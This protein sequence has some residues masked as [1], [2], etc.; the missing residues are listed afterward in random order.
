MS[1]GA[2]PNPSTSARTGII[3]VGGQWFTV[4]QEPNLAA[5]MYS[6]ERTR[7]SHRRRRWIRQREGVRGLAVSVDRGVE[8]SGVADDQRR[9]DRER[10]RYGELCRGGAAVARR[11]HRNADGCR[12]DLYG[13]ADDGGITDQTGQRGFDGLATD[14]NSSRF[15]PAISADG[16]WIAFDSK[17]SNL[18]AG[19]TNGL[20]DIFVYDAQTAT[21]ARVSVGP[22]GAQA[23]DNSGH[24]AI[25]ADGRFVAFTSF[26]TNLVPGRHERRLRRIR[27]RSADGVDSRVSAGPGGAAA[28]DAAARFPP[29]LPTDDGSAFHSGADNLVAEDTNGLYDVF[30]YDRQTATTTRVSAA[31]D[32]ANGNH[33]SFLPAISADGA[34]VALLLCQQSRGEGHERHNGR[35]RLRPP[36]RHD[37]AGRRGRAGE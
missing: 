21:I 10:R 29:S 14:H 1:Y 5:C 13:D 6:L 33:A 11:P 20:S 16:R 18:V 19:D 17:A 25:S 23:N 37:H 22:G 8:R 12:Q 2:A 31:P 4:T 35:V 7:G 9:I 36:N 30:L 26:A 28:N 15:A 34:R 24:P 3:A 27:L 32:G